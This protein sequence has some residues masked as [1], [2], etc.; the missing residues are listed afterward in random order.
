MKQLYR[1]TIALSTNFGHPYLFT[2][3]TC[4]PNRKEIKENLLPD[5]SAIRF[6]SRPVVVCA[7]FFVTQALGQGIV[8]YKPV[9]IHSKPLVALVLRWYQLSSLRSHHAT[10]RF[11][12]HNLCPLPRE[13]ILLRCAA[14]H[15]LF[16]LVLCVGELVQTCSGT[17]YCRSNACNT[18]STFAGMCI[19]AAL[20]ILV[21]V[22]DSIYHMIIR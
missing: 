15:L 19:A 18:V 2:T 4:S 7:S 5:E 14:L 8:T 11:P 21:A 10:D 20:Y 3:F 9:V 1:D 17:R 6:M 16:P 12:N 13:W 22:S